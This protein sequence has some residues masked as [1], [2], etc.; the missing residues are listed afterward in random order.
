MSINNAVRTRSTLAMA[1]L[2]SLVLAALGVVSGADRADAQPGAS[3]QESMIETQG[4]PGHRR[5]LAVDVAENHKRFF[6]DEAPVFE[7]GFPSEGNS[8]FTAGYLYPANTLSADDDGVNEDGSAKYPE[9]VIGEWLCRGYFIGEGAHATE[10]SW[11]YS[12]QVF[13][14]GRNATA[15]KHTV[16]VVGYEGAGIGDIVTG[17]ITGGSGRFKAAAGEA[18]QELLGFTLFEG[19]DA[20]MPIK[21]RV[22]LELTNRR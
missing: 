2:F 12:T 19:N 11:V 13:S 1:L 18:D 4:W 5:T 7:D 22:E 16:V 10:G 15:G 8:F 20:D 9:K 14:F 3:D 6:F 17:A 21:K